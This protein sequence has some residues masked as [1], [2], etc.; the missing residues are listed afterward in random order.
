M[1]MV[2]LLL[3]VNFM[4]DVHI[5]HTGDEGKVF[6]KMGTQTYKVMQGIITYSLEL[7]SLRHSLCSTCTRDKA[8]GCRERLPS[9]VCAHHLP[10]FSGLFSAGLS[11]S[12]LPNSDSPLLTRCPFG[13]ALNLGFHLWLLQT[14]QKQMKFIRW[15]Q[16]RSSTAR[17]TLRKVT[18]GIVGRAQALY[19]WGTE[20][21]GRM[22]PDPIKPLPRDSS[23]L[24]ATDPMTNDLNCGYGTV[25]IFTHV[26]VKCYYI[27]WTPCTWTLGEI[28]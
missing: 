6:L 8:T 4:P 17:Y 19:A 12:L 23:A 3:L 14:K 1:Y 28:T 11:V 7:F 26:I 5:W 13:S 9:I 16:I 24:A 27:S 20:F 15:E 22:A 18:H 2:F 25:C 10:S 21:D